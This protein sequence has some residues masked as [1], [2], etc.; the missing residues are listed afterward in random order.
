MDCVINSLKVG[1]I[2]TAIVYFRSTQEK[3]VSVRDL[4][5]Q[6]DSEA[7]WH[8]LFWLVDY[9]RTEANDQRMM[10][11][12]NNEFEMWKQRQQEPITPKAL[13]PWYK[14]W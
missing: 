1:D 12:Y 4:C 3:L 8:R 6:M 5:K 2:A 14:F 11:L 10:D 7:E 9:F 13:K